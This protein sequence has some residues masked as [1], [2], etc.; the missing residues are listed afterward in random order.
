MKEYEILYIVKP[1]LGDDR[2]AELN[3]KFKAAVEKNNGEVMSFTP[4]GVKDI[5]PTFE[6]LERGYYVVSQFTTTP[7]G[8]DAIQNLFKVE[9]DMVRYLNVELSS[10]FPE[11]L[12]PEVK[13]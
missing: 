12:E 13:S 8:L 9:E 3:D 5:A 4:Q 1:N 11:Q 10:V 2:Y 7:A 6:G